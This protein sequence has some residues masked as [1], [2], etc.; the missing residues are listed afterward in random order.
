MIEAG[1]AEARRIDYPIAVA[2]GL[3]SLAYARL[4]LGDLPGAVEA[5][6]EL[7]D[8]L[9]AR[10]ALANA[11]LARRRHGGA[12]PPR[13]A[14]RWADARRHR[15][16]SCRSPPSRPPNTS[17]CRSRTV[18]APVIGRHDVIATVRTVLEELAASEAARPGGRGD[19]SRAR[20]GRLD[21]AARRHL[22]DRLRRPGGVGAALEGA[23]RRR[24]PDRGRRSGGPLP[25]PRRR[26]RRGV[27]DRA[28]P[29]RH[30][31]APATSGASASCR[32]RSRRPSA[33]TTWP[34]C[35]R[36]RSSSTPSSTT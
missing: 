27:V 24:P 26:R 28:G 33:T 20:A 21:R 23:R 15:S 29:R 11:R 13:R 1:L 14:P 10:G 8:D 6:G 30:R 35:T 34:G 4:L 16:T 5:A 36:A 9:L 7:L 32:R 18:D 31:P 2:V 19:G 17:W 22:R 3:R 25:R 12:R